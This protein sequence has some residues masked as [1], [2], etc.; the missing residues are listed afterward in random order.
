MDGVEAPRATPD[1]SVWLSPDTEVYPN[2]PVRIGQK[3]DLS[4]KAGYL[5]VL[6]QDQSVVSFGMLKSVKMIH[7]RPFAEVTVSVAMEGT[8]RRQRGLHLE[9]QAE[10]PALVDLQSGRIAKMDLTGDVQCTG[11]VDV[12][13]KGTGGTAHL[14]VN[15]GGSIEFHQMSIAAKPQPRVDI[16]AKQG[17]AGDSDTAGTKFRELP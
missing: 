15:G 14:N 16:A 12:P 2:V 3:W 11:A 10:G 6:D 9:I 7:G 17:G 8:F 13:I 1:L 4:K 5:R